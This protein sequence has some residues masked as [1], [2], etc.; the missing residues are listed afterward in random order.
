M[1]LQR[2]LTFLPTATAVSAVYCI[3][4][5]YQLIASS[6]LMSSMEKRAQIKSCL[7]KLVQPG[8][9]PATITEVLWTS[10]FVQIKVKYVSR[11]PIHEG[12]I[13]SFS[14]QYWR[15]VCVVFLSYS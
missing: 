8:V 15:E 11:A 9:I 4:A 12:M 7:D 14:P 3:F 13:C 5:F 1:Q 6:R 2:Q 10:G